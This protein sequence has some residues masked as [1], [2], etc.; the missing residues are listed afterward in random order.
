[1]NPRAPQTREKSTFTT[2][3]TTV[4]AFA[5]FLWGG[6][7][8]ELDPEIGYWLGALIGGGLGAAGGWV[9]AKTLKA[10]F[11]VVLMLIGAA[12]AAIQL[13]WQ[14]QRVLSLFG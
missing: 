7:A 3:L 14:V 1:M 9:A 13:L 5:G 2:A 10:A 4:G 8:G 6:I 11:V 12:L